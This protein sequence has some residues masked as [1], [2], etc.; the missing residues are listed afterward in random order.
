MFTLFCILLCSSSF[1][2][3]L[4]LL[5]CFLLLHFSFEKVIK[6]FLFK[7]EPEI[8]SDSFFYSSNQANR[9]SAQ[10]FAR[11]LQYPFIPTDSYFKNGYHHITSWC[12]LQ[13]ASRNAEIILSSSLSTSPSIK[14][15]R[16]P[17]LMISTPLHTS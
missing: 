9:A 15:E 5:S 2:L 11:P 12:L 14:D 3:F 1:F 16:K 4:S 6:L 13:T 8:W 10:P 7:N 17:A